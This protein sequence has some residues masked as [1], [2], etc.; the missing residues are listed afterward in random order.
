MSANGY[1]TSAN[2]IPDAGAV[3]VGASE[4]NTVVSKVQRISGADSKN[5]VCRIKTGALTDASADSSVIAKLQHRWSEAEDWQLVGSQA[6]V[7]LAAATTWY[8]IALNIENSSDE[9][10]MP[11][12][13]LM[14]LVVTTDTGDSAVVSYVYFSQRR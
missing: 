14:R 6:Q 3:T 11:L 9:A 8:S 1:N 7:V 13:P 10:Q 5:L 12:A 2:M 4:T